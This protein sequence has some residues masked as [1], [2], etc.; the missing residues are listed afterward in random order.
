[1]ADQKNQAASE[2]NLS[3]VKFRLKTEPDADMWQTELQRILD[4]EREGELLRLGSV[5]EYVDKILDLSRDHDVANESFREGLRRI[6]HSWQPENPAPKEYLAC[7]LDLIGAYKPPFA[8]KKVL[9]F[10][11]QRGYRDSES[12]SSG[13]YGAYADLH[14]KA[15]VAL[16]KYFPSV[17]E[18]GDDES[19]TFYVAMLRRNLEDATYGGY[20]A[21]RLI[22][23]GLLKVDDPKIGALIKRDPDAQREI[24][25]LAFVPSRQQSLHQDLAKMAEHALNAG[26]AAFSIFEEVVQAYGGKLEFQTHEIT[27]YLDHQLP[28]S[29]LLSIEV[30]EKYNAF[31]RRGKMN[32]SRLSGILTDVKV[33]AQ[34]Q[35]EIAEI[36]EQCLQYGDYGASQFKQELANFGA[37]ILYANGDLKLYMEGDYLYNLPSSKATSKYA[38]LEVW[39]TGKRYDVNFKTEVTKIIKAKKARAA[40]AASQSVSG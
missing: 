39:S 14:L 37:E 2:E 16:E 30:I 11:T 27:I 38:C 19:F 15:L 33:R 22:D 36:L 32:L 35:N 21:A 5:E 7:L 18:H 17:L 40:R 10:L 4:G 8:S 20:V 34:A 1:M 28:L 9:F 29:L 25:S 12:N 13:G 6:V 23:L 31:L 24:L 26:D 3:A